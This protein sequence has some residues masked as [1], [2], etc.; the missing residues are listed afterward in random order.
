[1]TEAA[2]AENFV[3]VEKTYSSAS[4]TA[5]CIA[6][7]LASLLTVASVVQSDWEEGLPRLICRHGRGIYQFTDG[8]VYEGDFHNDIMYGNGVAKYADGTTMDGWWEGGMLQKGSLVQPNKGEYGGE[9]EDSSFHGNGFLRY[10]N[11]SSYVGE[12]ERG[13]RSGKGVYKYAN[14]DEYD[15]EWKA[16]VYHGEGR[17]SASAKASVFEGEFARGKRDG[18]GTQTYPN[19]AV[20]VGLWSKGTRHGNGKMTHS[21]FEYEGAW[22]HDQKH[23]QGV[24]RWQRRV[25]PVETRTEVDEAGGSD[26]LALTAEESLGAA[27]VSSEREED[28]SEGQY[29]SHVDTEN[30]L[31]IEPQSHANGRPDEQSDLVH[32]DAHEMAFE[33]QYVGNFQ[34]GHK[35]GHG[36]LRYPTGERIKLPDTCTYIFL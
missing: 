4:C 24:L 26:I 16:D 14:G 34:H 23:G 15:G 19:G 27:E 1:M 29:K 17:L 36:E 2:T 32:G 5:H 28:S 11:G 25:S 30:G 13:R 8:S 10:S 7:Q 12:W 21:D 31:Q 35:H 6:S 18:Q 22:A 20:Y 3:L 9:F 33:Y